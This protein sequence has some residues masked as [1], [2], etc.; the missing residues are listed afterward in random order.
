MSRLIATIEKIERVDNLHLVT[1]QCCGEHLKMV[2]LEL[3]KQMQVGTHVVL[4]C[5]PT[6]VAVAKI[7]EGESLDQTLSYTNQIAVKVEKIQQGV[8]LASV[9][10]SFGAASLEAI[11]TAESIDRLQLEEGEHVT[12]LI[13]VSELSIVEVLDD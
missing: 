12:A 4:G 9:M 5:K 1:F 6:A 13:K 10:L 7:K 2:S 11:V 3:G 8:L